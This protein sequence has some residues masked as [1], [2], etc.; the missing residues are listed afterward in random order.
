M[1]DLD[2]MGHVNNAV[3]LF[4][5]DSGRLNYFETLQQKD[6][7]W[8]TFDLVI[9]HI[10]CDF[11][12]SIYFKNKILVE[13]KVLEIGNKSLKIMQRIVEDNADRTLLSTCYSVLSGYDKL[14]DISKPIPPEFKEKI[15][16][17]EKMEEK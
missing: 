4:Y 15:I 10:S 6:I 14:N 13:T 11:F 2:A 5:Y 7:D 8:R 16:G 12:R 9:V 1:I 3:Q 17:F